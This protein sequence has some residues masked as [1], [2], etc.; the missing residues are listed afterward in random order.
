MEKPMQEHSETQMTGTSRN[1]LPSRRAFLVTGASAVAV[2][3]V[4]SLRRSFVLQT[5]AA[6]AGASGPV[7]LV[8]FFGSRQSNRKN[9]R[10]ARKSRP[11]QN[12]RRNYRL[13]PSK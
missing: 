1:V 10:T 12:G 7:T 5:V 13:S 3:A 2:A 8:A 6:G 4:W 9:H 11:K